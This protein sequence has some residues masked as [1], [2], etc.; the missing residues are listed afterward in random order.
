MQSAVSALC[1]QST[2][3]S[4]LLPALPSNVWQFVEEVGNLRALFGRSEAFFA[5]CL[6][7]FEVVDTEVA[8]ASDFHGVHCRFYLGNPFVDVVDERACLES[9]LHRLP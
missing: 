6:A 1:R 3:V 8:F 4:A 9:P 5:F 2:A 7:S